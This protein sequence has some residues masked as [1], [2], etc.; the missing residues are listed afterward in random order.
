M[1]V[2]ELRSMTGDEL[3]NLLDDS[4]Q[5]LFNLRFQKS[6]GQLSNTGRTREVRRQVARINTVLRERELA[7]GQQQ[8]A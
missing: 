6:T 4:K 3:M 1:K 7:A 2:Q 5:E 8:G